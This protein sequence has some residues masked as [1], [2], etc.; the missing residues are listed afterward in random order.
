MKIIVKYKIFRKNIHIS[1]NIINYYTYL[2][3]IKILKAKTYMHINT[4]KHSC[5]SYIYIHQES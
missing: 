4:N 1:S 5:V 2:E 3:K